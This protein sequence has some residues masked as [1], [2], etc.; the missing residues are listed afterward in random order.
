[1]KNQ[2]KPNENNSTTSDIPKIKPKE[3]WVPQKNRYTINTFTEAVNNNVEKLFKHKLNLSRNNLSKHEKNIISEFSKREDLVFTKA[4]KRGASVILDVEG[5]KKIN[6]ELK[7]GNYY[8]RSG[9]I[10]HRNILKS[11]TTQLKHFIVN[12]FYQKISLIF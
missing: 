9:M 12:R 10:Q 3:T 1:M 5:Y 11:S 2:N 6:K 4:D 7:D 8:K